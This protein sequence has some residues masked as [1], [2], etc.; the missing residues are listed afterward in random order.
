VGVLDLVEAYDTIA[1]IVMEGQSLGPLVGPEKVQY[2]A[3]GNVEHVHL[4]II[5]IKRDREQ[6]PTAA[7]LECVHKGKSFEVK[8]LHFTTVAF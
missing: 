5:G 3:I 6:N 1:S 4:K 7:L 2:S 8:L